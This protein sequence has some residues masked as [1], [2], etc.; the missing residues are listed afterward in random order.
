MLGKITDINNVISILYYSRM[1][2][3]NEISIEYKCQHKTHFRSNSSENIFS[4]ETK[5]IFLLIENKA[6]GKNN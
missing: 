4:M 1:S 2:Y 5:Q 3:T 6:S